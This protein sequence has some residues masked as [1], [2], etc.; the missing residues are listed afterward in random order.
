MDLGVLLWVELD[1]EELKVLANLLAHVVVVLTDTASESDSID[2]THGSSISTDVL[3]ETVAINFKSHLCLLVTIELLL[4]GIAHV[5][6]ATHTEHTRLLVEHGIH[7]CRCHA[8][9]LHHEGNSS[10]I[11]IARTSSHHEAFERSQTHSGINTLSID[12][13]RH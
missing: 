13:S 3:L 7:L 6:A 12:N 11:D 2:T 5:T 9:L 1:A 10:S 8:L 4:I